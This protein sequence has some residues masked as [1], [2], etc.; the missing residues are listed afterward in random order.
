MKKP[1][2]E[3]IGDVIIYFIMCI[4]VIIT[5]WPFIYIFS[6]SISDPINIMKQSVWI[7]PKG[8]SLVT[9]GKILSNVSIWRSYKNTIIVAAGGT[10]INL[11]ITLMAGYVLSRKVCF[12]KK[13][14]MIMLVITMFFGGGLIPTFL[15]VKNLGLYNSRWALILPIVTSTWNIIITRVYMQSNIPESLIESAKID[16]YNDITILYKIVVPLSAPIVAVVALFA[17]VGYWND[18]F[19][20]LV[21][22]PDR[23]KQPIS[24]VLRRILLQA[25]ADEML[26]DM[27]GMSEAIYYANQIKYSVIIITILPIVS[28]YPF[29]QKYFTKGIMV[30]SLKG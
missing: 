15:V 21:Y 12:F 9:Y 5:L 10:A 26:D 22:V 30:G 23:T 4:V 13:P 2:S 11:A 19:S 27:E 29:L 3:I 17:V 25:N 24:L 7:W 1:V 6:N 20:A 28:V 18:F 14:A 16:G 8:F